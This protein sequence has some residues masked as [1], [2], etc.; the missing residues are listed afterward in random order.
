M[1]AHNAKKAKSAMA[2]K[3]C[4]VGSSRA[5]VSKMVQALYMRPRAPGELVIPAEVRALDTS[6]SRFA[7]VHSLR[8][9][10]RVLDVWTV[11]SPRGAGDDVGPARCGV[12]DPV[13]HGGARGFV[14][15]LDGRSASAADVS[16]WVAAIRRRSAAPIVV[17][18]DGREVPATPHDA[19]SRT[20]FVR[21][22]TTAA[23][24][25]EAPFAAVM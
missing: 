7:G 22:D 3:V 1:N 17:A 4:L 8:F 13:V 11:C 25:L 21:V 24:N 16:R 15:L 9:A 19:F 20:T 14:V 2:T 12:E 5:L 10:G 23:Q 18:L 6:F